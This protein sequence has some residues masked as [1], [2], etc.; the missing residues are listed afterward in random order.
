MEE[1]ERPR[2]GLEQEYGAAATSE[3]GRVSY[4]RPWH[5]CCFWGLF[6]TGAAGVS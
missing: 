4:T 2:A 3:A 5:C 1:E 6:E